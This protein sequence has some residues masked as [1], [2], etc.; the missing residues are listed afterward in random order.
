MREVLI[1]CTTF[2][3][4]KE[5]AQTPTFLDGR[6]YKTLS[7]FL[8][9]TFIFTKWRLGER[10]ESTS[11]VEDMKIIEN[12][13]VLVQQSPVAI[14]MEEYIILPIQ[15][16]GIEEVYIFCFLDSPN[17]SFQCLIE[18]ER[19]NVCDRERR[20]NDQ[21]DGQSIP[22]Y[23]HHPRHLDHGNARPHDGA[24]YPSLCL[25]S[26]S[27]ETPLLSVPSWRSRSMSHPC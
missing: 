12:M 11:A 8:L 16:E 14:R 25:G 23:S 15:M 4:V 20:A 22:I 3:I 18:I 17:G 5:Q 21:T 7:L 1:L 27:H 9:F 6:Q 2:F 24:G 19:I 10:N 13:F 26:Q